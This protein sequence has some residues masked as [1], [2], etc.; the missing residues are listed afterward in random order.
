MTQFS[1]DQESPSRQQFEYDEEDDEI[2]EDEDMD[3][4]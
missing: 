4:S 3:E 1:D 2:D